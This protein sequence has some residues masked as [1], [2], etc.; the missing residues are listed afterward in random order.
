MGE[1]SGSWPRYNFH[2]VLLIT[3]CAGQLDRRYQASGTLKMDSF[4]IIGFG[5]HLPFLGNNR[6]GSITVTSKIESIT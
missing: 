2:I 3:S 4:L 5:F 6:K 1:V